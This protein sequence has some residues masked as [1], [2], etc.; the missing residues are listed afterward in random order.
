MSQRKGPMTNMGAF[1]W[2]DYILYL[3]AIL[4]FV[5]PFFSIINTGKFPEMFY[6][7]GGIV[8]LPSLHEGDLQLAQQAQYNF[9]A[10]VILVFL[11]Y[12]YVRNY[13]V[14]H[15]IDRRSEGRYH[16]LYFVSYNNVGWFHAERFIRALIV[17]WVITSTIGVISFVTN[18]IFWLL[19]MAVS[20]TESYT[21]FLELTP[22][23]L[24]FS[25]YGIVIT[26]LFI[27]FFIW[28]LL[29]IF[30]ISRQI[31]AGKFVGKTLGPANGFNNIVAAHGYDFAVP[32]DMQQVIPVYSLIAY[33]QPVKKE[34]G[35]IGAAAAHRRQTRI[36]EQVRTGK[37]ARIYFFQS[38]KFRERMGGFLIGLLLLSTPWLDEDTLIFQPIGILVA[39]ALYLPVVRR[40]LWD[41]IRSLFIFIGH[42]LL[43]WP[44]NWETDQCRRGDFHLAEEGDDE[45]AVT[46]EPS[47]GRDMT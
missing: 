39:L 41:T 24:F 1:D 3:L 20:E 4:G 30:S 9:T 8:T 21:H 25:Y 28:D 12:V 34:I 13:I 33:I 6:F 47:A 5:V 10:Y 17:L 37:I 16:L 19:N 36:Q 14:M 11:F 26:V 44:P 43:Y 42:Y 23:Q 18:F 29:N 40:D 22:L 7:Q 38:G 45:D 27:L 31:K 2:A 46:A 32:S 15:R 35:T